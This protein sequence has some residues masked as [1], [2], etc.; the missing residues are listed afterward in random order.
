MHLATI[1]SQC[2]IQSSKSYRLFIYI[3]FFLKC[4]L[5]SWNA[6]FW[7]WIILIIDIAHIGSNNSEQRICFLSVTNFKEIQMTEINPNNSKLYTMNYLKLCS[8]KS[9]LH[10]NYNHKKI[11]RDVCYKKLLF[12]IIFFQPAIWYLL[13]INKD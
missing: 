1:Y 6:K 9:T 3:I 12:S 13:G 4:Y 7:A 2:C 11:R 5:Q 10:H 8:T